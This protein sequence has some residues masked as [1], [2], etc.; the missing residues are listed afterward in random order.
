MSPEQKSGKEVTARS[1]IYSLGLVLYEIFTGMRCPDP[2]RSPADVVKDLDPAI[3]SAI[4]RCLHQDPRH[5]PSSALAVA[6]AL[7]GGDPVAAALAAGETPSPEMVAASD[8]KEKV[9][10]RVAKLCFSAVLVM[11]AAISLFSDKITLLGHSS[12]EIPPDGLAFKAREILREM[13][14]TEMPRAVAYGFMVE[15]AAHLANAGEHDPAN[16]TPRLVGQPANTIRF[17]YR[18]HQDYF[19]TQIFL[20]ARRLNGAIT[21]NFP[22]NIAPGMI[23]VVL[24]PRGRLVGLDARPSMTAAE[25]PSRSVNW[26]GLLTAAV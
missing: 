16:R 26:T 8:E 3:D 18:Q 9:S 17:W 14:Y 6:M 21:S 23:R 12:V 7:P 4:M 5:R 24:D 22:P 10:G 2:P 11:L 20:T 25:V 1:D 15:D 13:G 19:E